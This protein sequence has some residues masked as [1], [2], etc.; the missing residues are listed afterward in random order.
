MYKREERILINDKRYA[1]AKKKKLY[2]ADKSKNINWYIQYHYYLHNVLE[3]SIKPIP[4]YA[5]FMIP[6]FESMI[7]DNYIKILNMKRKE[8]NNV[9][10]ETSELTQEEELAIKKDLSKKFYD[11]TGG[12]QEWYDCEFCNKVIYKDKDE[13]FTSYIKEDNKTKDI[14][15]CKKC[16]EE[17]AHANQ[18]PCSVTWC[19][20]KAN[21]KGKY[22]EEHGEN[23]GFDYAETED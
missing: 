21:S 12:Y 6:H 3:R 7:K 14:V 8:N 19:K 13:C 11:L 2:N 5:V 18:K 23:Q 22:C 9:S 16:Y 17:K 20:N 15:I 4:G 1:A 10:R